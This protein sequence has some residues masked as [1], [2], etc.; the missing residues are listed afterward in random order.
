MIVAELY[1]II[2]EMKAAGCAILILD[3]NPVQALGVCERPEWALA[4]ACRGGDP[5]YTSCKNKRAGAGS[6][7]RRAVTWG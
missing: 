2:A 4:R 1:A 3:H 5:Y 6:N 7:R